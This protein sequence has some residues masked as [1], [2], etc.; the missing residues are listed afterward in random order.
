MNNCGLNGVTINAVLYPEGES[1][2][3][4]RQTAI[5]LNAYLVQLRIQSQRRAWMNHCIS[6]ESSIL[7]YK[8]KA[9]SV[10]LFSKNKKYQ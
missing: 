5:W 2:S 9:R 4:V 7:K 3:M 1:D 8:I 10:N 6:V